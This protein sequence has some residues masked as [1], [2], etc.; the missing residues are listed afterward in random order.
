LAREILANAVKQGYVD[1]GD[2]E[3]NLMLIQ[4]WEERLDTIVTR[5]I[6]E[7]LERRGKLDEL[8]KVLDS[9]IDR[10]VYLTYVIPN[11]SAFLRNAAVEAKKE[12]LGPPATSTPV[13][14]PSPSAPTPSAP[15]ASTSQ[16]PSPPAPSPIAP[17]PPAQPSRSLVQIEDFWPHGAS[18]IIG[19]RVQCTSRFPIVVGCSLETPEG[20]EVDLPARFLHSPGLALWGYE[21]VDDRFADPPGARGV[22]RISGWRGKI[23]FALYTDATHDHRLADTGWV[24]WSA[25]NVFGSSLAS[26]DHAERNIKSTIDTKYAGRILV[27]TSEQSGA[28]VDVFK[29]FLS[30]G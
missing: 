2:R 22:G 5:Q 29:P 21:E 9:D 27:W 4:D 25:R 17:S 26:V 13:V 16:M 19:L 15:T 10:D 20:E 14:A 18:M 28:P 11:Y 24:P 12:I 7:E 30:K 1:G 23:I 8:N 3:V 6:V